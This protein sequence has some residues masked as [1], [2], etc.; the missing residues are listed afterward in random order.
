MKK[1]AT[2]PDVIRMFSTEQAC[3]EHLL[4]LR[5]PSGYDCPRCGGAEAAVNTDGLAECSNC[6]QTASLTKGT[7]FGHSHVPMVA[8]FQAIWWLSG[9]QNG[10]SALGLKNVLGLGSYQTAWKMLKKIRQVMVYSEFDS[11][12]GIVHID[13]VYMGTRSDYD[14]DGGRAGRQALVL[15]FVQ[16]RNHETGRVRF[17]LIPDA[18]AASLESAVQEVVEPGSTVRTDAWEG[19]AGLS[20]LGYEHEVV[21]S[22]ADVGDNPI[23]WCYHEISQLRQWLSGTYR[24]T[25]GKRYLSDYLDEYTFRFN[26]RNLEHRGMIFHLLLQNAVSMTLSTGKPA[27]PAKPA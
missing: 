12:R 11:L 3:R 16:E 17:K 20:G 4:H 27:V 1:P 8:W 25:V 7:I 23:A 22:S 21:R 24:G 5:W 15:V 2:F 14:S 10:S 9:Q 6:R 18:D 26:R 13:E 19:Y